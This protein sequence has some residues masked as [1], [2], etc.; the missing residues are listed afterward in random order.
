MSDE[1]LDGG[2]LGLTFYFR[3]FVLLV[4]LLWQRLVNGGNLRLLLRGSMVM[5]DDFAGVVL[6]R[7]RIARADA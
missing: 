7:K 2:S 3:S 6:A 5:G 4:C 1:I